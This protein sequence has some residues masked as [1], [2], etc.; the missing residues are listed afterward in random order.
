MT[1]QSIERVFDILELLSKEQNG[2]QLTEIGRRLDL[3]KST[4]Y[5]L[6]AVLRKRGYIEKS[7]T[8][9]RYRIGVGFIELSSMYLN[10]IELKTEA[11]P[12]L[13][14]L[15][16]TVNQT[17]YL[18]ML[19][20]AEVIYLDK[21]EQ[22]SSLRKY[23]VIGQRRPI[24]CT[25]LGK[26]MVMNRNDEEIGRLFEHAV[27]EHFTEKTIKDVPSLL[28]DLAKCRARGWTMDDEEYEPGV[29]CLGAPLYDYRG[30]AIAAISVSWSMYNSPVNP[31][32]LSSYVVETA[33]QIS[34][35]FGY[36]D[37][38]NQLHKAGVKVMLS[39]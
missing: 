28:K 15:S 36:S 4:V 27:F 37:N 6:L 16:Q 14:K 9:N 7:E 34:R 19:Q 21:F 1:V 13:R 2:L 31:E 24:Y 22:F 26:A 39:F 3:H 20:D 35:R 18:A 12:Y 30:T 38:L 8:T 10:N 5:R 33:G 11:E 25:S 17:V 23:S 29:Q 32:E